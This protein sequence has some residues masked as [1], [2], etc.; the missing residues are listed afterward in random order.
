MP[1]PITTTTGTGTVASITDFSTFNPL[2]EDKGM[3][4]AFAIEVTPD[5]G[6]GNSCA[7]THTSLQVAV[8]DKVSYTITHSL[9]GNRITA[10]TK[11]P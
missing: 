6:G 3:N 5:D 4:W 7:E 10:V 9:R 2:L 11:I 8:G 1:M